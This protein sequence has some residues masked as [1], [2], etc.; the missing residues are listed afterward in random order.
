MASALEI[1][2][3]LN[4]GSGGIKWSNSCLVSRTKSLILTD[5]RYLDAAK[6][7]NNIF[8]L[9]STHCPRGRKCSNSIKFVIFYA[10]RSRRSF[11]LRLFIGMEIL[12]TFRPYW[13]CDTKE[14]T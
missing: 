2:S 7:K 3:S 14:E 8:L 1:L 13:N 5:W 4:Y 11:T 6:N 9:G 10:E 12:E